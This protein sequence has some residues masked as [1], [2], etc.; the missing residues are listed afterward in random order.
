[1]EYK[2]TGMLVLFVASAK[3]DSV[4]SGPDTTHTCRLYLAMKGS[5]A[6]VGVGEFAESSPY[7]TASLSAW[8]F[9]SWGG[10][11]GG[12]HVVQTCQSQ[13]PISKLPSLCVRTWKGVCEHDWLLSGRGL[14]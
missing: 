1:M 12:M 13:R 5:G 3:M 2:F 10:G 8:I 9:L 6:A 14:S 4:T 7:T 11:R